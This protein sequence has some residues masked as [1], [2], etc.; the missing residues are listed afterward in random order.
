M[1]STATIAEPRVFISFAGPDRESARR[2]RHD[3]A[4]RGIAAFFASEDLPPG[5]NIPAILSEQ[6]AE[7]DYFVLLVS[8]ASMRRPWVE[9]EWSAAL[10][11][12]VNERRSFLFLLR[13]DDTPPPALLGARNFLDAFA[14]WGAAVGRLVDTW[15]QDYASR[16]RGTRTLPA[17]GLPAAAPDATLGL[18]VVNDAFAVRHYLRV[19]PLL[20]GWQLHAQVRSLLQLKDQ[21]EMFGGQIGMRF[22]YHLSRGAEELAGDD[23]P[24][25]ER[26]IRDG[27]SLSLR[28]TVDT[29][30]PQQA[31]AP[32]VFRSSEPPKHLLA[33]L[34]HEAFGHLYPP[35]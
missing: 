28:V 16:S 19:S 5:G 6:L 12:E 30:M 2:L 15:R 14:D 34:I 9:V 3:L 8:A 35:A 18:Y 25:V 31:G 22:T 29:F 27:D 21:V 10:M 7:S 17:P 33:Q 1:S 23:V 4:E 26:G 13:L 32:V 24:L 20:T 11:R